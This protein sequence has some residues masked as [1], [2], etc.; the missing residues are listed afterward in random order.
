MTARRTATV[1]LAWRQ[2]WKSPA[3]S[4]LIAALVA[5]PVLA[6]TL[7]AV[8]YRTQQL[9]PDQQAQRMIGSAD[10]VVLATKWSAVDR[11]AAVGRDVNDLGY[12]TYQWSHAK[13]AVKRDPTTV[14]VDQLL[15]A[16]ARAVPANWKTYV[17]VS[18]GHRSV[19]S[20]AT[21]LDLSDPLSRGI[22]DLDSGRAPRAGGDVVLTHHLA[23]RLHV[24]VGAE[25]SLR[26]GRVLHVTGVGDDPNR[27]DADT[28]V[29]PPS[30][31]PLSMFRS[32][33]FDAQS[34]TWLV[35]FAGSAPALHDALVGNGVVY[36]SRSQWEHP[37]VEL[38]AKTPVDTQIIAILTGIAGFGLLEIVLL[39]GTAFAVGARRQVR[40]LGTLLAAGGD[41][42]DVRRVLLAQGAL[43][44]AVGA[45][46]GVALGVLAAFAGRSVFE[47]YLGRALGPFD[48]RAL[49]VLAVLALGVGAGLLAALVPARSAAQLAVVDMLRARFAAGTATTRTPRWA[50]VALI[51]GPLLIV[52]AAGFWHHA[53]TV[54][55]DQS[56]AAAFIRSLTS[57]THDTLWTSVII[58]GAAVTL[59]GLIRLCPRLLQL[60]SAQGSRLGLS[61]R[62]ALRDASRHHHRTA[63][64]VAAVMTVLAGSVLVLFT[65]SSIDLRAR[66]AYLP[67]AP[68]GTVTA[69]AGGNLAHGPTPAQ[70]A[71]VTRQ[72]V[73]TVGDATSVQIDRA[74]PGPDSPRR[75]L[76]PVLP[77]CN[78]RTNMCVVGDVSVGAPA[79][80]DF[81]AGRTVPGAAAMLARGGA[82]VFDPTFEGQQEIRIA[83]TGGSGRP[84]GAV[85]LP[86]LIAK[87]PI[88]NFRPFVIV[89]ADTARSHGWTVLGDRGLV[90]PRHDVSQATVDRLNHDLGGHS[91]VSVER[92][93]QGNY[94]PIVLILIA[95]SA[96]AAL[97]GTSIAVALAMAESRADSSTLAAVGAPPAQRRRYAMAQAGAV[98]GLGAMLGLGLGL[99]VSVALFDGSTTYPTSIPYRW[100]AVLVLAAPALAAA[101]AGLVTRGR[102]PMTRRIA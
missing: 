39:A 66:H 77:H 31:F 32:S 79:L 81:Y 5:L 27:L 92:G 86:M 14:D 62:L 34:Y 69:S 9:S 49:D 56:S 13:G 96:L 88:Y 67:V 6:G 84:V 91:Y 60:V 58:I 52:G 93:Y 82:V 22:F 65:V 19:L 72:V 11:F 78:S 48:V 35:D 85:T 83:E 95:V 3:R 89:S 68:V 7:A 37:S 94:S 24:G 1:R 28:I 73:A 54:R 99:L 98:G 71:A 8:L 63:P 75:E 26:S 33:A 70:V 80:V 18:A 100:L 25:V 57:S 23:E 4:L 15:P 30:T 10:A 17:T 21:L 76:A 44:G 38:S 36:A 42:R 55:L 41:D 16:S 53:R 51:L 97:G 90:T 102:V 47:D 45:V 59:A 61:S 101:V 29:G 87:G 50:W 74:V 2:V 64:A 40:E 12:Q 46:A 20:T 43:L